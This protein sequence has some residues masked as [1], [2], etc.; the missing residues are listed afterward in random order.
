[1]PCQLTVC[2]SPAGHCPLE[3]CRQHLRKSCAAGLPGCLP[4][5]LAPAAM[6]V[7]RSACLGSHRKSCSHCKPGA[8]MSL[9]LVPQTS[10][11][12][13]QDYCHWTPPLH[14]GLKL[15]ACK[16]KEDPAACGPSI[17]YICMPVKDTARSC[18]TAQP[19]IAVHGKVAP[20]HR[21]CAEP[22]GP[23]SAWLPWHAPAAA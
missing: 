3:G 4:L 15:T 14:I 12:G 5:P 1:M 11:Q 18:I 7:N 2:P 8:G 17:S 16:H 6:H 19:L 22:A 21:P 23:G 20:V 13:R 9:Q 10:D